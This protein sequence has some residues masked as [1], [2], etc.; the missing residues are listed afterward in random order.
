M[1]T[2]KLRTLLNKHEQIQNGGVIASVK[3]Q[4]INHRIS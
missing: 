4:K 3:M 2:E 1:F